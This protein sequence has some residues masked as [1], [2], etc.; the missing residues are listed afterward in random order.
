MSSKTE[1]RFEDR[2]THLSIAVALLFSSSAFAGGFAVAEQ[3]AS[4]SGRGSTAIA[5]A[6]TAS[7]IQFN[8]A[9]LSGLDGAAV[10]AGATVIVPSA[11][12]SDPNST[13]T[14]SAQAGF[15]IPPHV[16]GAYGFGRFS[17]GAGFNAP[18][19]GGLKWPETWRGRT[20]LVEMNLQVLAGHLGGSFKI[21][22]QLSIGLAGSLYRASVSLDKRIDFVDGEGKALLGGSGLGFGASA[23]IQYTPMKELRIGLMGR[24][25]ATMA[26]T[27]RVHFEDV[28]GAFQ[29]TLPDQAI[30]TTLVLPAKIAIGGAA[31]LPW[32][33]L[34]ADIEYTFWSS[35]KTFS[36]DFEDPNTPDV[37]QPRNWADAP[38]FRLGAER[39][40]GLTTVRLGGLFDLAA[41]PTDTLS[42][43]LPD[44]HRIGFSAGVGR[45]FGPFR[46]D[47]AYQ[48]IAF[49][50]TRSTG[51]AFPAAYS[52]NAHLIALSLGWKYAANTP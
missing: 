47:L 35:F 32:L 39:D 12:A 41:S 16:Y 31:T 5:T 3:D 51:E 27:G 6:S 38:T 37:N 42:P 9:G 22:D 25:P 7:S 28:P 18:F 43:S 34:S 36:V 10:S 48:F 2:F 20:D 14:A 33:R 4:A 30:R 21:N 40:F 26:M 29:N 19:G 13:D 50:P 8:P 24:I 23:G 52:A 45:A 49:L 15:K 46:A 44:S 11:T 17:I 1:N